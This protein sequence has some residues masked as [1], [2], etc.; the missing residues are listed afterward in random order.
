MIKSVYATTKEG[1][2]RHEILGIFDSK[3]AA[4]NTA[5]KAAIEDTDSHHNYEVRIFDLNFVAIPKSRYGG[6]IDCDGIIIFT[7]NKDKEEENARF[8][9]TF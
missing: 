4:I 7:T 1:I 6:D 8:R 9:T 2:Y 5:K 3:D